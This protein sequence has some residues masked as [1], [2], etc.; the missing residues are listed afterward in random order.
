MSLS[1]RT[2]SIAAGIVAGA[3]LTFAAIQPAVPQTPGKSPQ[4]ARGP[5]A[6]ALRAGETLLFSSP[7]FKVEAL[8][9]KAN[10][11]TNWY[12]QGSD[13]V[14]AIFSD[15]DPTHYDRA[16]AVYGNVDE[17]DTVQFKAADRCM[18]PQPS[19]DRGTA[20][21]NIRF[22]FWE[23]D[24]LGF[25]LEFCPGDFAGS[26]T[27]LQQGLCTSD[28]LIG[29]G[30]IIYA[31]EDLLAMLPAVG[32]SREF[33][34]VMDKD[35]GIYRF[36]Y[37]ITRLANVERSIVVHLPPDLGLPPTITLQATVVGGNNKS[38]TLT[39]SGATTANVDINRNGAIIV[40]TPNDGTH[41]DSVVAGTYQYRVC[42][43][44]STTACSA[45][46][47]VVVP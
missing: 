43:A 46:V 18:G 8:W 5:G 33:T 21:L 22:S 35:A 36:R 31:Q 28:D 25:G 24:A 26:H 47:Q 30:E 40:T 37:R 15:M 2:I 38:V 44:G 42:N 10:D 13:E 45:P 12:W 39:W 3:A 16:T 11:E 41:S 29:R 27:R 23:R 19:C 32:D 6:S 4:A 9:F 7:Q 17:G 1:R 34:K 14:Y 20:S